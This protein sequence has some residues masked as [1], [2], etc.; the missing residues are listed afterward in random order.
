MGSARGRGVGEAVAEG[1][2]L[3][4]GRMIRAPTSGNSSTRSAPLRQRRRQR[5]N[6]ETGTFGRLLILLMTR[7][8]RGFVLPS[9]R[10]GE[11]EV[12]QS[13]F[14][15]RQSR[16]IRSQRRKRGGECEERRSGWGSRCLRPRS[17]AY[18]RR[19]AWRPTDLREPALRPKRQLR[20]NGSRSSTSPSSPRRSPSR[21]ARRSRGRMAGA[22]ATPRRRPRAY[23]TRGRSLQVPPS[24]TYS[25]RPGPSSTTARSIPR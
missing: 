8:G 23:G 10:T 14:R 3:A 2:A 1:E 21:R 17:S 20:S 5:L 12:S 6:T 15:V 19:R 18:W 24:P 13:P 11:K 7:S 22:S 4:L 25:R 9:G 16:S